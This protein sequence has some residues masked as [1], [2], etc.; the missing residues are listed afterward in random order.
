M[1]FLDKLLGGVLGFITG[2]FLAVLSIPAAYIYCIRYRIKY[3][4]D[5]WPEAI[6]TTLVVEGHL[7]AIGHALFAVGIPF[8]GALA[9]IQKGMSGA[10]TFPYDYLKDVWDFMDSTCFKM[11]GGLLPNPLLVCAFSCCF[12][13]PEIT[14]SRQHPDLLEPLLQAMQD[15]QRSPLDVKPRG[16][17]ISLLSPFQI[18]PDDSLNQIATFLDA[19]SLSALSS[20]SSKEAVFFKP[21]LQQRWEDGIL[22]K[23]TQLETAMN[24]LNQDLKAINGKMTRVQGGT[25]FSASPGGQ[26]PMQA[27]F[28]LENIIMRQAAKLRVDTLNIIAELNARSKSYNLSTLLI[29]KVRSV[30]KQIQ[31]IIPSFTNDE[32]PSQSKRT[33]FC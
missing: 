30:V 6:F 21:A 17:K 15:T 18:L 5:S 25:I 16:D 20:A 14:H 7:W 26:V 32:V 19:N 2:S 23:V 13:R 9:G 31:L 28:T 29:D 1:G 24:T 33:L 11:S 4:Q 10:V 12:K 3:G 22:K 27:M 8:R